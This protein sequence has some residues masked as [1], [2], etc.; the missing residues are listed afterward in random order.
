[1]CLSLVFLEP[2]K[3][4]AFASQYLR[5]TR[6]RAKHTQ[7]ECINFN[8]VPRMYEILVLWYKLHY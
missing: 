3:S 6:L 4:E 5:A 7:R 1:M 2:L 8:A